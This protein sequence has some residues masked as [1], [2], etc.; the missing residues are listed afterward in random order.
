MHSTKLG[1]LHSFI[2]EHQQFLSYSIKGTPLVNYLNLAILQSMINRTDTPTFTEAMN[3]SDSDSFLR[4]MESEMSTLIDI[5]TFDVVKHLSKQQVLS[6]VWIFKVKWS[7]DGSVNKLKAWLC[8]RGFEQ[9]EGQDYFKTFLPIVQWL[10]VYL[11]LIM[12]IL[13]GLENQQIDNTA[14]F[15]QAPIDTHVYVEMPK[16]FSIPGKLLE[17]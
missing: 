7:P 16:L 8:A 6:S 3:G 12:T 14:A 10:T 11:I 5:D 17:T 9:I 2:A 15:V 13:L 4:A 1:T